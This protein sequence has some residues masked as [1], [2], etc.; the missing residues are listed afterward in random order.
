MNSNRQTEMTEKDILALVR[1]RSLANPF[2]RHCDIVLAELK[3]DYAEVYVDLS[4][5]LTNYAGSAHGGLLFTMADYCASTT[6]RTDGRKYVTLNAEAHYLKNAKSGRITA[7]SRLIRRG[8]T[9]V[10]VDVDVFSEE[11]VLLFTSSITL[12]CLGEYK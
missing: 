2:P 11:N 9:S 1:E 3:R 10:L 12:F 7:K 8:R 6:A 4:P 5:E